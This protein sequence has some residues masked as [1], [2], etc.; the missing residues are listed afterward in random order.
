MPRASRE[1]VGGLHD[2]RLKVAVTAPPVDGAANEA[3][4]SAVARALGVAKRQVSVRH[5]HTG[6]QKT[7]VVCGDAALL[8]AKIDGL[9]QQEP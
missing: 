6:R 4:C 2:G 5:G 3:V 8:C 9:V 1:R 7:L